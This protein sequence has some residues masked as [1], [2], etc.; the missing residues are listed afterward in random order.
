MQSSLSHNEIFKN[1]TKHSKAKQDAGRG[2][3]VRRESARQGLREVTR[4][5]PPLVLVTSALGFRPPPHTGA[6]G[7]GGRTQNARS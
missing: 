7:K 4:R 6:S 2:R 1:K 3:S 5:A